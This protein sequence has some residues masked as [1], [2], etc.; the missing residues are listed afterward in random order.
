MLRI[1]K[2]TCKSDVKEN[3][4][5]NTVSENRKETSKPNCHICFPTLVLIL[6][7]S[8][9][10]VIAANICKLPS[11]STACSLKTFFHDQL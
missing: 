4:L 5:L 10:V 11:Y 3:L 2:P 8:F 7:G 9:P 6:A 1:K